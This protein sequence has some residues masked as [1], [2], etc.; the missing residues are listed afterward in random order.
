[1]HTCRPS[2]WT[3]PILGSNH[4]TCERCRRILPTK[5]IRTPTH[6]RFKEPYLLVCITEK[7]TLSDLMALAV[8][9]LLTQVVVVFF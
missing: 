1:M 4:N 6:K 3:P 2:L 9:P 7:N 8:S 5:Y